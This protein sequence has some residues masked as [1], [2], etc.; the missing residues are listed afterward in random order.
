MDHFLQSSS[1]YN[2]TRIAGYLL[3]FDPQQTGL[4]FGHF[5]QQC[6]TMLA[7]LISQQV[8]LNLNIRF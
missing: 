6:Y 4:S 7:T 1:L 2:E 3:M 8:G 5:P